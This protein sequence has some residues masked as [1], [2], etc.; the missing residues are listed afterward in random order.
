[1]EIAIVI[2]NGRTQIVLTPENKWETSVISSIAMETSAKV[3]RGSF[4]DCRGGWTR[5]GSTEESLIFVLDSRPEKPR[6]VILS[7]FEGLPTHR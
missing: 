2:K 7:G 5:E 1:M 3:A 4:Y 6:E